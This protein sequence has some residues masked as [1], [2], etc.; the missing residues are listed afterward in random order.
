MPITDYASLQTAVADNLARSDLTTYIPD[1]VTMAENWLNYGSDNASP[2]R[3]REMEELTTLTP[4]SGVC[5]LPTDYIEY[6]RVVEVAGIRRP[7]SYIT[8]DMAEV[9]YPT[10]AAGLAEKFTIIGDSLYTF[11]LAANDIELVYYQ[12]LPPLALN[13]SNWLLAKAPGLYLR[14]TLIQAAEFIK[15]DEEAAK[16]GSLAKSLMAGLN[17]SD[18]LGKY[19]RAGLTPRGTTP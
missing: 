7:L 5:T 2:L 8:L 12:A 11:P 16:Q 4:A 1:F 9:L 3:C 10:R 14:A 6:R 13:T 15:N 17:H 18:M 19:A